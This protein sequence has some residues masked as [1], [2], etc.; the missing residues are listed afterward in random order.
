MY[1]VGISGS[2]R[3]DGN[4]SI[5][6]NEILKHI[7]GEKRFISLARLNLNPCAGCNKCWNE[8]KE[9]PINDDITWIIRELEK[10]DAMILGS[11]SYFGSMSAQLKMLIDRS[12]STFM[13]H[14]FR[15][16]ILGAVALEDAPGVGAGGDLTLASIRNTYSWDF[17]YAGGIVGSGGAEM[18]NVKNDKQALENAKNLA[19]RINELYEI[20]TKKNDDNLKEQ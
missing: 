19:E 17:I 3:K 2:P 1:V 11:P 16:K 15:N 10:C 7:K 12:V 4:T 6:V 9:C 20:I 8:K 13:R 5:L 18:G 14:S